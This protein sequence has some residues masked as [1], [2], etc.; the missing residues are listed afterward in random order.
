MKRT[1]YLVAGKVKGCST[2]LQSCDPVSSRDLVSY[3]FVGEEYIARAE[4]VI[5]TTEGSELHEW[6]KVAS[7]I[8]DR[9]VTGIYHPSL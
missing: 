3:R 1:I 5:Q 8:A 6:I 9:K 2:V 4:S 7:K